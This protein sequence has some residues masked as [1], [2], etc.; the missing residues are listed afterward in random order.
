MINE[1]PLIYTEREEYHEN[2]YFFVSYSHKDKENVYNC[3]TTLYNKGANYWYDKDLDPG[4]VWDEKVTSYITSDNCIGAIVFFSINMILSD[5][6]FEEIKLLIEKEKE[7]YEKEQDFIILPIIVE[8]TF[9]LNDT[10]CGFTERLV[11]EQNLLKESSKRKILERFSTIKAISRDDKRTFWILKNDWESEEWNKLLS[12]ISLSGAT[13]KKFI[14]VR[15]IP[16][17]R[18]GSHYMNGRCHYLECGECI[19]NHSYKEKIMWQLIRTTKSSLYFISIYALE[20]KMK[21]EIGS[22]LKELYENIKK[23][24]NDV[25][26]SVM[27]P[28]NDTISELINDE[29][30]CEIALTIP[31]DH[32]DFT[33]TQLL[34]VFW[35]ENSTTKELFLYNSSNIVLDKEINENAI[36]AGIRPIIKIK[37]KNIG[38]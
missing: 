13:E 23:D 31:T 7:A 4:D 33:R 8:S 19:Q 17:N 3:L 1:K 21:N 12:V 36:T 38:G 29:N 25:P 16:I 27:L 22:Y 5:A 2:R 10:M 14:N 9:S 32:A 34:R 26:F 35:G 24:L 20:F 15:G 11:I 37:Q 30:L 28:N 6:C 18:I